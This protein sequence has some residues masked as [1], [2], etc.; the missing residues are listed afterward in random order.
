M[1]KDRHHS[2][3]PEKISAQGDCETDFRTQLL[4]CC[5]DKKWIQVGVWRINDADAAGDTLQ[6]VFCSTP[7]RSLTY[8]LNE[9]TVHTSLVNIRWF[10]VYK[11]LFHVNKIWMHLQ[12]KSYKH[13]V[14]QCQT[15]EPEWKWAEINTE[16]CGGVVWGVRM[17]FCLQVTAWAA[18]C[19]CARCPEM[20]RA[21]P[22][23]T[24]R[25]CPDPPRTRQS[26]FYLVFHFTTPATQPALTHITHHQVLSFTFLRWEY[27]TW[28]NS[29]Q[30]PSPTSSGGPQNLILKKYEHAE[31]RAL[32]KI[33]WKTNE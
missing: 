17:C 1:Q 18:Q 19:T 24:D 9:I 5:F 21:T 26:T 31:T 13:E 32:A 25:L 2:Y 29:V 12:W 30:E 20:T 28:F 7:Q 15:F 16:G 23:G 33:V 8:R 6:H 11:E 10:N 3:F 27:L 4:T 14:F 22:A